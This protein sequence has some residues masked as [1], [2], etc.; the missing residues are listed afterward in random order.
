MSHIQV[1]T[2]PIEK[3]TRLFENPRALVRAS[4]GLIRSKRSPIARKIAKGDRK[5]MIWAAKERVFSAL[6]PEKR[7]AFC[8]KLCEL[9][10]R[11]KGL[12]GSELR[13]ELAA[14]VVS[15]VVGLADTVSG[16]GVALVWILSN[17]FVAR[18]CP[19]G[20][21]GRCAELKCA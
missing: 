4:R 10:H 20:L 12:A 3:Y 9:K 16:W 19:C 11:S 14:F 1:E 21:V 5:A 13:R 8:R 7:R 18:L 6:P 2:G 15:A 17:A